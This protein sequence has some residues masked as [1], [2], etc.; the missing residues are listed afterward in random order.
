MLLQIS[1]G[2]IKSLPPPFREKE[3]TVRGKRKGKKNVTLLLLKRRK[4]QALV[5]TFSSSLRP[6]FV[7]LR[8][9][10]LS[11]IIEVVF[12]LDLEEFCSGH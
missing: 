6:L 4:G 10:R 8:L 12:T 7:G 1:D 3:A 2:P 11:E 5:V 9:N